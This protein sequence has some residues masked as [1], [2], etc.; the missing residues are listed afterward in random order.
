MITHIYILCLI[1]CGLSESECHSGVFDSL[2]PHGL[3]SPWNSPGH[4][5]G[6][7]SFS[8]L[9]GSFPT[10]RSN[11]GL[12]HCRQILY[13]LRHKG[14]PKWTRVLTNS[15]NIVEYCFLLGIDRGK[16]LISVTVKTIKVVRS[17]VLFK[18]KKLGFLLQVYSFSGGL[19]ILPRGT[20]TLVIPFQT[21]I[22]HVEE[23][24]LA[25]ELH[26]GRSL[27]FYEVFICGVSYKI[28]LLEFC[29]IAN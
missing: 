19:V 20:D 28:T 2:W 25:N 26:W 7:G 4:N 22:D 3:Y 18:N 8:L 9:R 14:S 29:L 21:S 15:T 12:P 1:L 17:Y 5:T 13:Q 27:L 23:N 11:P 16:S 10:Q 24:L 6:L